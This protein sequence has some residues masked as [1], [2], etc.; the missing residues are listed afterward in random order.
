MNKVA[1]LLIIFAGLSTYSMGQPDEI[2]VQQNNDGWVMTAD[3]EPIYIK[4][5]NWSHH[6]VGTTY[7]YSL[8]EQEPDSIKR[9][10]DRE[11]KMM[12]DIGVNAI[13]VYTGIQKKWITY[14]Y[15]NFGIYT[16][17]NHSFGRYGLEIEGQWKA[18]TDYTDSKVHAILLEEVKQLARDYRDT[19]GLLLY[20]LG[21]ENNYGLFW[22]GAETEDIPTED[23]ASVAN[24]R[25]M[26][27][28]FNEAAVQMKSLDNRV[29]IAICNG[30]LQFMDII[31][32]EAPD[33]DI[34]GINVYRGVSFTDLFT[35]VA[36]EYG[37]PVL[38]T[39][40]GSDAFNTKTMQEDQSAQAYYIKGNWKDIYA[41]AAGFQGANNALG[42]FTFQFADGWWKFD[43]SRNLDK[44]DVYASW[45]NAGYTF[46]YQEEENNM[47]EEWFGVVRIDPETK[48][49]GYELQP[50]AGYYILQ[51]VHKFDPY[52]ESATPKTLND[53]FLKISLEEAM[54]KAKLNQNSSH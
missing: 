11:M 31:A 3:G 21:N 22:E 38:L 26:Y 24:A 45:S 25:A 44:H 43:Q 13:R 19:E 53:F 52:H 41:N 6:P 36:A 42:G 23:R 54:T 16:M 7:T 47:N 49:G 1:F 32:E 46:D 37:K 48:I 10:L 5:M 28:L 4:G 33:I 30:D 34:L 18:N 12:E 29:P 20:L 9:V 27:G 15:Q 2:V 50:R 8:W 17:L 39:E 51:E 14:I 40:F 35:R